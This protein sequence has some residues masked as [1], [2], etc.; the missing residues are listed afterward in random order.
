MQQFKVGGA[1]LQGGA[2][3]YEKSCL[4]QQQQWAWQLLPGWLFSPL[5]RISLVV[6]VAASSCWY[7]LVMALLVGGGRYCSSRWWWQ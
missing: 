7:C 3:L 1:A 2:E 6:A 4:G 5:F